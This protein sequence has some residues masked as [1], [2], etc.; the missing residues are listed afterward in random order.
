MHV[1]STATGKCDAGMLVS[2]SRKPGCSSYSPLPLSPSSLSSA[3]PLPLCA[4][5]ATVACDASSDSRPP[6][7]P[8]TPTPGSSASSS[9]SGVALKYA[10]AAADGVAGRPENCVWCWCL[11]CSSSTARS[12]DGIHD[13][14]RWQFWRH[15][16]WP[17]FIAVDSVASATG[18]C[19]TKEE[20][21]G[22][23]ERESAWSGESDAISATRARRS[24]GSRE[25]RKKG[26]GEQ[27]SKRGTGGE[28]SNEGNKER[29]AGT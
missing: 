21:G 25:A 22:G 6:P 19:Q 17:R 15:T 7:T 2:H 20:K 24:R 26:G 29:G 4:A 3:P 14:A 13:R 10:D 11:A 12:S 27:A 1:C 16:Q 8:P 23:K 5:D 18:P 28:G 9:V